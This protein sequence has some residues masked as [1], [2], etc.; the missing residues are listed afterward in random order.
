ATG[1]P[2][3]PALGVHRAARGV[4]AGPAAFRRPKRK[5]RRISAPRRGDASATQAELFDQAL[6][7]LVV[8]ALEIV[9]QAATLVDQLQQATAAVV[10]LL[11]GLEV[12]G[13]LHDARG[14]QG[15][16]DFRRA[17]IVGAAL[18]VGDDFL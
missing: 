10:V 18:V 8:L 14:E 15:D 2:E 17:G 6:V 16:L 7:A 9:E 5:P 1:W 11:V 3:T 12:L 4:A 13:Q